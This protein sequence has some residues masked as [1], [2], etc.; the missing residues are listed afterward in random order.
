M[1]VVRSTSLTPTR[2]S[3]RAMA[4]PTPDGVRPSVPAARDIEP[5]S[6]TAIST[7]TP[8]SKRPS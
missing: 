4:R 7:V 1:R 8:A 3:K 5:A 6:T 2:A